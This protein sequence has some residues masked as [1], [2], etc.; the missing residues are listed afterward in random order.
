MQLIFLQCLEMAEI[1]AVV[2]V[3]SQRCKNDPNHCLRDSI[4]TWFL[5]LFSVLIGMTQSQQCVIDYSLK[6][7][8]KETA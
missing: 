4:V 3:C 1:V 8:I 6:S 2:Y 5:L 7:F